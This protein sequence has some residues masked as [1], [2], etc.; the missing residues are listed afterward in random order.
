M[1]ILLCWWRQNGWKRDGKTD[2]VSHGIENLGGYRGREYHSNPL[3]YAPLKTHG[4]PQRSFPYF[5]ICQQF[6]LFPHPIRAQTSH[7]RSDET[8]ECW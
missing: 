4:K 8:I 2:R 7:R 5:F 1:G 3:I 6:C